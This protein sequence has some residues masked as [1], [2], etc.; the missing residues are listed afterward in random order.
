MSVYERAVY[1]A[2]SGNLDHL[3]PVC[4]TWQDNL[5]AHLRVMVDVR[6]E[7]EVRINSTLAKQWQKLPDRYWNN[8]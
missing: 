8:R 6:V 1:A 4:R 5:W 2:Y 3:L 7:Q